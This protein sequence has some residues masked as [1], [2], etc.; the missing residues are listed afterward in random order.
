MAI[1]LLSLLLSSASLAQDKKPDDIER[2]VGDGMV[3]ALE[4]RLKGSTAPNDLRLLAISAANKA[5]RARDDKQKDPAFA[6]AEKRYARWIDALEKSS[7]DALP[8]SIRVAAARVE[9]GGMVLA[10]WCA[11][12]L[13]EFE[14]TLGRRG[15]AA[16]IAAQLVKARTQYEDALKLL[17][18]PARELERGGPRIEEKLLAAGVLD[19]LTQTRLDAR[20]NLGWTYTYLALLETK[21]VEQRRTFVKSAESALR[22][23]ITASQTGETVARCQLGLG[24]ALRL[25]DRFEESARALDAAAKDAGVTPLAVQV[26]VERARTD[27]AAGKFEDARLALR[28]LLDVDI[29]KLGPSEQAARYFYN[30]AA[31]WDANSYLIES[32]RLLATKPTSDT[33]QARATRQRDAGVT[34]LIQLAD[35]GGPWPALVQQIL[36]TTI[37]PDADLRTLSP[38]ELLIAARQ[39]REQKRFP[40]AV[41]RLEEALKRP[42]QNAD[43]TVE[44]LIELGE[45]RAAADDSRRAAEAFD[46]VLTEFASHPQ[47][48]RACELAAQLWARVADGT[49]KPEDYARLADALLRLLERFPSSERREEAQWWLPL[50][51]ESAGKY[52]DA[53]R[54]FAAIA[55]NSPRYEQA[56]FRLAMCGRLALDLLKTSDVAQRKVRILQVATD[57]NAY[58]RKATE[59]LRE[60]KT[61]TDRSAA[62]RWIA[63]A[64]LSAAELLCGEDLSA[65]TDALRLLDEIGPVERFEDLA[66]RLLATRIAALRGAKRFD[67]AATVVEQYLKSVPAEKSGSVLLA[68]A[69]GMQDELDRLEQEGRDDATRQLAIAA[70][71]TFEQLDAIVAADE[72]RTAARGGV[73]Y[74][75]ARV[76]YLA[77]KNAEAL[78]AIEPL[79]T[80]DARNGD[81][82]RL[83][84]LT[85][86]AELGDAP[87]DAALARTREAWSKLLRDSG[88]RQS[89]PERFWEARYHFLALSLREGKRDEVIKAIEQERIWSPDLSNSSWG[90]RLEE[91][92]QLAS[93]KP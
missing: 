5:V 80:K 19:L 81:V 11:P 43:R 91:L 17:E 62:E 20:F 93:A 33:L 2:M 23:S 31:I 85:L 64:R 65:Y 32:Q 79:A 25:A 58:A 75:L 74:A 83:F 57:L 9:L 36:A 42:R 48:Q 77:G 45:C 67:E 7:E 16:K 70:L 86:T 8:R 18:S 22:E 4:A 76:R 78:A 88:L 53:S 89:Q 51:L 35:R 6:D 30:L 29:S 28:P 72:Q 44:L 37:K 24:I 60:T 54:Q 14:I 10:K 47:A 34:R 56:Q 66:G 73:R 63:I 90:K 40:Q 21:S 82:L 61:Q 12:Q 92:Y 27:I 1:T 84:A 52:E 59:R 38:M 46:R 68:L 71:P 26:A 87:D 13:D 49:R 50:A 69:S 41:L 39:L 3:E 15:D 55:P